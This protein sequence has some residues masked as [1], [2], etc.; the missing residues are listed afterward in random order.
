MTQCHLLQMTGPVSKGIRQKFHPLNTQVCIKRNNVC[1]TSAHVILCS[2]YPVLSNFDL[3]LAGR[4]AAPSGS[5]RRK[6]LKI[7]IKNEAPEVQCL[8][9]FVCSAAR[10]R[11]EA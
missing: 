11:T 7:Q 2:M 6:Y 3:I 4:S 9:V 1:S 5:P 8:G 10:M